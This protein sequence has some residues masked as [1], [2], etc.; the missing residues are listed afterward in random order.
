MANVKGPSRI[1]ERRTRATADMASG[2][3]AGN[4][5]DYVFQRVVYK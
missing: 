4:F 3:L 2:E 1:P 5:L